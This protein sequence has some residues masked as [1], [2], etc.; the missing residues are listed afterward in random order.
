MFIETKRD[1][2]LDLDV[3]LA[4]LSWPLLICGQVSRIR[5]GSIQISLYKMDCSTISYFDYDY[6]SISILGLAFM[7]YYLNRPQGYQC[8]GPW[9]SYPCQ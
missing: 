2:K 6:A 5:S 8:H 4:G 9:Y 7:G 1:Y 3:S